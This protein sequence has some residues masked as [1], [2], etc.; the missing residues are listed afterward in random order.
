MQAG[1]DEFVLAPVDATSVGENVRSRGRR[2]RRLV[3]DDVMMIRSEVI[4]HNISYVDDIV[5]QSVDLAPPTRQL[6]KFKE[7]ST[8]DKLFVVPGCH[9]ASSRLVKVYNTHY[10]I[11][12]SVFICL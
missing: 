3:I 12:M 1:A 6:M 4:K 11:S 10:W 8:G 9:L 2:R 7:S 5:R